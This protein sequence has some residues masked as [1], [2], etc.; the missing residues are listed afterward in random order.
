M[1]TQVQSRM[2]SI[3]A[4]FFPLTSLNAAAYF[5]KALA[6]FPVS[7][8]S[9]ARKVAPWT[10]AGMGF[11]LNEG[12]GAMLLR[13]ADAMD[14]VRKLCAALPPMDRT[15]DGMELITEHE[16]CVVCD[17]LLTTE[18]YRCNGRG[19]EYLQHSAPKVYSTTGPVRA[20]LRPKKCSNPACGAL[21]YLSYATGG[22]RLPGATQQFYDGCTDSKW[23]HVSD[24]IVWESS[25]LR[26]LSSLLLAM[27]LA[28]LLAFALC[29]CAPM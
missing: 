15:M 1:L 25:L 16:Q 8:P 10:G 14:G 11:T 12:E 26:D 29:V 21:H 6:A 28:M 9:R 20:T 5:F 3:G 19:E 7:V 4:Q 13:T 17:S 24:G 27:L 2:R 22:K 23:F 18:V